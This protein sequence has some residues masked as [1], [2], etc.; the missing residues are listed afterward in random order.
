MGWLAGTG[1]PK[2][3]GLVMCRETTETMPWPDW[4]FFEGYRLNGTQQKRLHKTLLQEANTSLVYN[5]S[6]S[7]LF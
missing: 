4:L 2:V 5:S 7:S 3:I 1:K 6:S